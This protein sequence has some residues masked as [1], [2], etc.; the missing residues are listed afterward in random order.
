MASFKGFATLADGHIGGPLRRNAG[1]RFTL[2]PALAVLRCCIWHGVGIYGPQNGFRYRPA[3]GIQAWRGSHAHPRG[4][5]TVGR[6]RRVDGW[7]SALAIALLSWSGFLAPTAH[8]GLLDEPHLRIVP[9]TGDEIARIIAVTEPVTDFSRPARFEARPAGAATVRVRKNANAFSDPSANIK[10][11]G[12]MRF[13]VGNGL[14]RKLWVSA[15]SRPW[16]RTASDRSSMRV[17][18]RGAT[19]RTGGA[20]HRRVRR[21]TPSPSC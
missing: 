19:S 4:I 15:P 5:G 10:F 8:A 9:R 14:F 6:D 17:P 13:K 12:E 16:L 21:T 20:I 2:S 3:G 11:E 7:K 1:D 18:A